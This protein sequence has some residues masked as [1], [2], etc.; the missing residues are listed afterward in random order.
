MG[1]V[2][3]RSTQ[4]GSFNKKENLGDRY[5]TQ[6]NPYPNTEREKILSTQSFYS[7]KSDRMRL[8]DSKQLHQMIENLKE[9]G[10]NFV[11]NEFPHDDSSIGY[12]ENISSYLDGLAVSN[13]K[14]LPEF[15][16]IG[17]ENIKLFDR[18]EVNDVS[19]SPVKDCDLYS[20]LA[21]MTEY[22]QRLAKVFTTTELN[23]YGAYSVEFLVCGVPVEILLDDYFPYNQD[24][25][26]VFSKPKSNELWFLFLEKAIAKLYGG[27]T[28]IDA[29]NMTEAFELVTGMP[30]VQHNLKIFNEK[31]L[32]NLMKDFNQRNYIVC[33]GYNR[34]SSLNKNKH[35]S[36]VGL[37]EA[38][39]LKMVKIRFHYEMDLWCTQF[40][41][42][43]KNLDKELKEAIEYFENEEDCFYME[44]KEMIEHFD[45][46]SVCYY[47]EGWDKKMT[48]VKSGYKEIV[49]FEINVEKST[50]IFI[51][52][53]QK[54]PDFVEE[55]PEYQI[56]PVEI[57]VAED[58]KG[59]LNW[60]SCGGEEA[61]LGRATVY[62]SEN[63]RM[64]LNQG[65]Y[66][67][68]AKVLWTDGKDHEFSLGTLS[69]HPV[70]VKVLEG[71][72]YPNFLEKV[73]SDL[74]LL[75]KDKF[76]YNNDCFFVS[77]W[78]GSHLWLSGINNGNKTWNLEV[79]FDNM[80]NLKISK[81]Y[82]NTERSLKMQIPPGGRS[83][84]FAKRITAGEVGFGWQFIQ[85]WE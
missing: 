43:T 73:Y 40:I 79:K 30:S 42:K 9:T 56:S 67:V 11:D 82:R 8:D 59:N 70:N 12:S 62:A 15:M 60:I 14:R 84:A 63:I 35:F 49:L 69:S 29:L 74:A 24:N 39:G 76:M 44:V 55:N 50:E 58:I 46:L 75:S 53:H 13:W 77:G 3:Q 6:E 68:R 31:T 61:F 78:A 26:L 38:H 80:E 2:S 57:L 28:A 7:L 22:P 23:R 19:K 47:Q 71:D 17:S 72:S 48:D 83:I 65:K 45:F 54:T 41:E 64:K 21:A 16:D 1:H 52:V 81:K 18:F 10:A 5:E 27:Y 20:V 85:S 36:V 25:Q 33:A 66:I 32:W 37:Y 34:A 51:S 4:I